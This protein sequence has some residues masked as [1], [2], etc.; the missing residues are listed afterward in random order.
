MVTGLVTLPT[1]VHLQIA[2]FHNINIEIWYQ[3]EHLNKRL[4]LNV[5]VW[6]L[7]RMSYRQLSCLYK[8]PC[9]LLVVLSVADLSP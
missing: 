2:A 7:V 3:P 5:K 8:V 9:K 6:L 1:Q 4:L